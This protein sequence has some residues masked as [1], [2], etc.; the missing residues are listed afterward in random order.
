MGYAIHSVGF[1]EYFKKF[2]CKLTSIRYF[3]IKSS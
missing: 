3:R 2:D 1:V